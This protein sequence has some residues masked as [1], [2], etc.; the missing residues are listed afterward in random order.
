MQAAIYEDNRAHFVYSDKSAM[1]LHKN[2]DCVTLYGRNGQK[3]RQL[4]KY[5][6]NSAAR[7]AC[8]GSLN[9]LLLGL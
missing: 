2:G 5:A 6:T 1:V 4:V 7:E 3:Y 9:K 8:S